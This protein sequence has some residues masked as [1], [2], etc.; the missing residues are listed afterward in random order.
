MLKTTKSLQKKGHKDNSLSVL[1]RTYFK[2][3]ELVSNGLNLKQ[4]LFKGEDLEEEDDD[5]V[6]IQKNKQREENWRR[7]SRPPLERNA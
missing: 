7:S 3:E 1:Y 4:R 5:S 6:K 2:R